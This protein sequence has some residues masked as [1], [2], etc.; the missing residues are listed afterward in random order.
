M[1]DYS[2]RNVIPFGRSATPIVAV[3]AMF[4][5]AEASPSH[6][7]Q[8]GAALWGRSGCAACHGNL[9]AGD[10]DPAYPA[11]PS[12]RRTRL[13]REQLAAT[14]ACGRPGTDMPLNLKGAYTEVAC[15]GLPLGAPP[16]EVKG[17]GFLSAEE[18]STLVDFLVANVVGKTRI[19]R[20]NCALFNDG[21]RNAPECLQF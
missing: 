6:A 8:A 13:E 21:N 1:P 18:I 7:Q 19:T 15:Y 4:V 16:A 10:G 20:D 14:I 12:L 2:I 3:V 11:G 5:F 17:K 9:A